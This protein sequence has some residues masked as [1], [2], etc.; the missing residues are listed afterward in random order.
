MLAESFEGTTK[1]P[2]IPGQTVLDLPEGELPLHSLALAADDN[3]LWIAGDEG[4][5]IQRPDGTRVA[6]APS[7]PGHVMQG[8]APLDAQRAWALVRRPEPGAACL[9]YTPDGGT[10]WLT[11]A[12]APQAGSAAAY[13]RYWAPWYGA[14]LLV[15]ASVAAWMLFAVAPRSRSANTDDAPDLATPDTLAGSEGAA[16]TLRSDQPVADK[17]ADRLG[18][19][20]AVEAL[21]SFIRNA[22]TEP[23]VTIAVTGEWGSGKSS[24]MRMLQTDLR[25]AGFRTAWF[26]AWHHQQEGRQ[27]SALF[28]AVRRQAVPGFTQQPA[29]WLRIRFRLIWRRGL[30]YQAVT[31]LLVLLVGVSGALALGDYFSV[32][33][34]QALSNLRLH[35]KHHLLGEKRTVVTGATLTALDPFR[36]PAAAPAA[37]TAAPAAA[38]SAPAQP[39][40]S[41]LQ[42]AGNSGNGNGSS[43]SA[44]APRSDPC[45][46]PANVAKAEPVRPV[47]FCYMKRA[48]LWEAETA[49]LAATADTPRPATCG[50]Q[51]NVKP[52]ERCVFARPEDLI[53]TIEAH[54]G[55]PGV[56]VG[57]LWPSE[58]QAILKAAET[59]PPPPL[60]P[61]FENL[62]LPLGGLAGLVA[63]LF[64]KGISVYGLQLLQPLRTLVTLGAA[65]DES[66]KEPVGTVERYRA[67]F[68]LLTEALDG[69]LVIFVDDLDRCT[70]ETVNGL[71]ELTN[72]MVDIGR[73]F[74]VL[75]AAMERVKLCIKPPVPDARQTQD[76]YARAY[77]RKLV[78]IELPVPDNRDQLDRLFEDTPLH[79]QAPATG[80]ASP[81]AVTRWWAALPTRTM[82]RGA[83]GL[84]AALALV[85]LLQLA[86]SVGVRLQRGYEGRPQN[87]VAVAPA[88]ARL[89]EADGANASTR[90]TASLG[91]AADAASA[92]ASAPLGLASPGPAGSTL[93]WPLWLGFALLAAAGLAWRLPRQRLDRVTLMLGGALRAHDS[94]RFLMALTIW[95]GVV[96]EHDPTPRHVKRF[97]NRARLF[98]AY[99]REDAWARWRAQRDQ[100]SPANGAA[101]SQ[102]A[103]ATDD[104]HVL[105]LAA[106]HHTVPAFLDELAQHLAADTDPQRVVARLRHVASQPG[107]HAVPPAV[108]ERLDWHATTFG[109]PSAEQVRRFS[110]RLAGIDVR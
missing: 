57:T 36:S 69:R 17:A 74:I 68:C 61:W 20:P 106:L 2:G 62:L 21:S 96:I 60:F 25:R 16:T 49:A 83:V 64:T 89:P 10:T 34:E 98:S 26:N 78:H 81:S 84:L 59:L 30:G 99:E 110:A 79:G 95:R 46:T 42:S 47:V 24:I 85:T 92:P 104:A 8:V 27:L 23:R 93:P 101:A 87:V 58:R 100:Q 109:L 54:A 65:R 6:S 9:L 11:Q 72:Y 48:L 94:R 51:R 71:M 53:A 32:G 88:S 13:R 82:L 31:V 18:F 45:A 7:S 44:I 38:G 77:L 108:L 3:A 33:R 63:L 40:G 105:M 107:P 1:I 67:E 76:E 90:A 39:D 41:S 86:F 43:R 50:D 56:P 5:R 35:M 15:L 70:P 14:T 66:A 103:A 29:A 97:Y 52:A 19:R 80:A 12:V 37:T 55:A 75:G 4:L 91:T 22:D 28:N 73:C 102:P